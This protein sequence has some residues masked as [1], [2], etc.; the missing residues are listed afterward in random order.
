M[1]RESNGHASNGNGR[2]HPRNPAFPT[3]AAVIARLREVFGPEQNPG[4]ATAGWLIPGAGAGDDLRIRIDR[5]MPHPIGSGADDDG[6]CVIWVTRPGE[7][8]PERCPIV[9]LSHLDAFLAMITIARRS[10][11]PVHGNVCP[12]TS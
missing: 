8:R 4:D 6:A 9:S 7:P 12:G 1:S 3:A 5:Q 2:P 10:A 11:A